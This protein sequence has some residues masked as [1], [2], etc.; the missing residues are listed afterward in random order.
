VTGNGPELGG[1]VP[2]GP[3][4]VRRAGYGAM[5]LAGDGVFGRRAIATRRCGCWVPPPGG[6][7]GPSGLLGTGLGEGAARP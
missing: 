3:W 2:L 4:H 1:F 6:A 5:Q 7:P